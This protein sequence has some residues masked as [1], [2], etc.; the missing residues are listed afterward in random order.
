M[1]ESRKNMGDVCKD[2]SS[3]IE[4]CKDL[5]SE[6]QQYD[7]DSKPRRDEVKLHL[8]DAAEL[9]IEDYVSRKIISRYERYKPEV[10]LNRDVFFSELFKVRVIMM[11]S[12]QKVYFDILYDKDE[13][14]NIN[15]PIE[16]YVFEKA[17]CFIDEEIKKYI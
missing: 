7:R 3:S 10:L 6:E 1:Y 17:V 4:E 14:E 15:I 8:S 13:M 12:G 11:I 2:V 5:L 16:K 9:G